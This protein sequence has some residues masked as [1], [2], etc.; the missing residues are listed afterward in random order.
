MSNINNASKIYKIFGKSIKAVV[1]HTELKQTA[2]KIGTIDWVIDCEQM[3]ATVL[4]KHGSI[5]LMLYVNAIHFSFF[6]QL[7]LRFSI[8]FVHLPVI[9]SAHLPVIILKIFARKYYFAPLISETDTM[10]SGH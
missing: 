2:H 10:I 6:P 5:V 3:G 9:T 1:L 8:P 7:I 4:R